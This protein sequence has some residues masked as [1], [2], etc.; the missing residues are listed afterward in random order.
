MV[1]PQLTQVLGTWS[2]N[3]T[4][5]LYVRH[6]SDAKSKNEQ[7]AASRAAS[8]TLP[9]PYEQAFSIIERTL[10]RL[11]P[12]A[13]GGIVYV[14]EGANMMDKSRS[15]FPLS[16]PRLRLDAGTYATIGVGLGYAIAAHAAYNGF[17]A[18]VHSGPAARKKI[19]AL[20]GDSAFGFSAMEVE[21]MARYVVD[22]LIFVMNNGGVYYGD[23]DDA[24]ERLKVRSQMQKG[25][26]G[27]LRSTS[28]GREVGYEKIAEACGGSGHLVRT[29]EELRRATENGFRDSKVCV[30]N[31]IVEAGEERKLEFGWQASAGK[32]K[33]SKL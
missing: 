33:R 14:S 15:I 21:T 27:G 13:C 4:S 23:R 32:K 20:E 18:E 8:A 30:V 11:S 2:F 17:A 6:P 22:V 3:A 26:Q 5:S 1:V 25:A 19:I 31:V 12:P 24:S 10:L 28:L 16:H 29:P 9:M 7:T